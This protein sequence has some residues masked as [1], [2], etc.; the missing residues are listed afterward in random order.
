MLVE[1]QQIYTELVAKAKQ[2]NRLR[3]VI[4]ESVTEEGLLGLAES[5]LFD[6]GTMDSRGTMHSRGEPYNMARDDDSSCGGNTVGGTSIGGNTIG[7]NTVGGVLGVG[8]YSQQREL[9]KSRQRFAAD[10]TEGS[11]VIHSLSASASTLT[12]Y[13]LYGKPPHGNMP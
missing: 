11:G 12:P 2:G 6:G 3:K 1:E 8:V 4:T 10:L 9:L 7:S 13:L 5:S